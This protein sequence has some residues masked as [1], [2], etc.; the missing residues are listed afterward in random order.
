MG[1]ATGS[2]GAVRASRNVSISDVDWKV[3]SRFAAEKASD[4][5]ECCERQH[6]AR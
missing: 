6:C 3:R 4:K 2:C 5:R 1:L